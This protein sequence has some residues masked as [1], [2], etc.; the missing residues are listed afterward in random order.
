MYLIA[1][2]ML[3]SVI[4]DLA[5]ALNLQVLE[6]TH[7]DTPLSVEFKGISSET[8]DDPNQI[9]DDAIVVANLRNSDQ[10]TI[11]D[12]L[13]SLSRETLRRLIVI[14]GQGTDPNIFE[15]VTVTSDVK[16]A[17]TMLR[18]KIAA[19]FDVIESWRYGP[20]D[21]IGTDVPWVVGSTMMFRNKLGLNR[22][23]FTTEIFGRK[24]MFVHNR[25][26]DGTEEVY[27]V[28]DVCPHR[29]AALSIAPKFLNERGQLTV[30]CAYHHKTFFLKQQC[31][32]NE[33]RNCK[34]QYDVKILNGLL[35]MRPDGE[36]VTDD[37]V[38]EIRRKVFS[39]NR[40]FIQV[41]A[42]R[43]YDYSLVPFLQSN[44]DVDHGFQVHRTTMLLRWA[45][46]TFAGIDLRDNKVAFKDTED[47]VVIGF[48]DG[49]IDLEE[50][51]AS[52][53]SF[54]PNIL[55]NPNLV[56][57]AMIFA[58]PINRTKTR[59]MFAFSA[60]RKFFL[61]LHNH[62]L[63]AI[64]ALITW[65]DS[66]FLRSQTEVLGGKESVIDRQFLLE[67][68][69]ARIVVEKLRERSLRGLGSLRIRENTDIEK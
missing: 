27:A 16:A 46:R 19:H 26:E 33:K 23:F 43:E 38:E 41:A 35:I 58:I 8:I 53:R 40:E 57:D 2:S 7:V 32:V 56:F 39:R 9:T 18:E 66:P 20:S 68:H 12:F 69:P 48:D 14:T 44:M 25:L 65:E 24:L 22:R 10:A 42:V 59:L 36:N 3:V 31:G 49:V 55:N 4:G 6:P 5:F 45:A 61:P 1:F 37:Q 50:G 17:E 21:S 29:N 67:D 47:G 54:T 60:D 11:T 52:F 28:D 64:A 51:P 30:R 62:L 15:G 13:R 34:K 63:R